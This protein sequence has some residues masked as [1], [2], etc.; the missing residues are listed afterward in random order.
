MELNLSHL[1]EK[2]EIDIRLGDNVFTGV[3]SAAVIDIVQN[4]SQKQIQK[5]LKSKK[6]KLSALGKAYKSK[7]IN[8]LD[9]DEMFDLFDKMNIDISTL[10][11]TTDA[12]YRESVQAFFGEQTYELYAS[13]VEP[14]ALDLVNKKIHEVIVAE[15]QSNTKK[16]DAAEKNA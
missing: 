10:F 2:K 5:L 1:L 6:I 3:I 8:D 9:N 14:S 7:D 16:Q 4:Q 13:A 11:N 12:L 15:I